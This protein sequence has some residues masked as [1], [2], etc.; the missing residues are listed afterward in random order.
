MFLYFT[1][2]YECSSEIS[3]LEDLLKFI[4]VQAKCGLPQWLSGKE[5]ACGAG[6]TGLIP[7]S[8]RS[9]GEKMATHSSILP[10]DRG[11][12]WL[13]QWGYKESDMTEHTYWCPST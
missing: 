2:I 4:C 11:A 9:P 7:G 12:W 6:D 5:S 8:G 10:T 3:V 13:Q 1:T